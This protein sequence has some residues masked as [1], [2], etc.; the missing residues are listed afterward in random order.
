MQTK[1]DP[2]KFVFIDETAA[3]TNMTRRYAREARGERLVCEVP[4]GP[5]ED[6]DLKRAVPRRFIC[7]RTAPT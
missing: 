1:L 4:P 5:L 6:F 3:S 2:R 7:R